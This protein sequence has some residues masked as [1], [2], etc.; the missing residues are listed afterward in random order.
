MNNI[1]WGNIQIRSQPE[2]NIEICYLDIK[3]NLD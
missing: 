2:V 1:G 3:F